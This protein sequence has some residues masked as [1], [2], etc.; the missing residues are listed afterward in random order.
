MLPHPDLP[1]WVRKALLCAVLC[2]IAVTSD[3]MRHHGLY[4]ARLL[5][6]QAPLGIIQGRILVWVAMPF[7]RGSSQPRD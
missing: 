1:G 7:S 5:C 3:S 6:P 2:L 4:P